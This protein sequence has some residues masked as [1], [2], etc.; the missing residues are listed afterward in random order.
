[1]QV[2][3]ALGF[4]KSGTFEIDNSPTNYF[5]ADNF[6][7]QVLRV[8]VPG[9]RGKYKKVKDK[10]AT[11]YVPSIESFDEKRWALIIDEAKDYVPKK[12]SRAALQS[13]SRASSDVI[14]LGSEEEDIVVLSDDDQ[15]DN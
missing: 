12:K 1:M 4:F 14:E 15:D 3:R 2:G 9:T 11:A 10:R 13:T 6:G 7:D 5:S 8:E